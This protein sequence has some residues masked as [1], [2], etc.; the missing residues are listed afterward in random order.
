MVSAPTT[1]G[2][3]S[4]PSTNPTTSFWH[5]DPSPLL[6][7]HRTTP[8]LPTTTDVIIIGSGITGAFA[9][10]FLHEQDASRD[11]LMLEAR[12]ACWGATGR[13]GGHCQPS[14]YP[15]PPDIG[16]FE[17]RNYKFLKDFVANNEIPCEWKTLEGCHAYYDA[18]M[19]AQALGLYQILQDADPEL[20][21]TVKV[22][23]QDSIS[24]S[25]SDLRVPRAVG[26]FVQANAA[27]LW[28]YKLVC[29]TL[30]SL[31]TKGA[32]N[33]QTNT[34]VTSLQK[35]EKDG[36]WI[37]HTPQGMVAAKN[38]ILTTNAYTSHLLPKMK[39]LIV[40]VQGE[41]SALV[42]PRNVKRAP[43]AMS[44]V[45]AGHDKVKNV[46]QDDYLIQRPSG[47]ELMFGGGRQY[48][49]DGGVGCSD[50]SWT[51]RSA[52]KYLRNELNHALDLSPSSS[53]EVKTLREELSRAL[54]PSSSSSKELKASFEWTGIMGFSRDGRPWVGAVPEELG[55]G[56]GLWICAGFT[57]H[58]M[59]NATGCAKAVVELMLGKEGE[60]VDL[61][62]VHRVGRERVERA[63]VGDEVREADLKGFFV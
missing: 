32:F 19:F 50:D 9:A 7:G 61:P 28:P 27:S 22:I 4:L 53:E 3:S 37:V 26:A 52:A 49:T 58:G 45:F 5:C 51:S 41:M 12:E 21:G 36:S 23:T 48:A 55:G 57:G 30:E 43:L 62:S 14:V 11:V 60:E 38:V 25:L 47:G 31:L 16:G 6:L 1:Q 2:Q 17:L 46:Y 20:S 13:N 59:P 40:P 24:P 33:L 8:D 42:A 35:V 54:D 15:S 63:R 29:W 39:D 56:K 10:H 18:D 34:P 44:Y